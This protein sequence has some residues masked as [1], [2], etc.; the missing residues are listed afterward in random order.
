ML[1]TAEQIEAEISELKE[2]KPRVV[3]ES[4]FGDNNHDAIEA[5]IQTLENRWTEDD[6]EDETEN[7]ED[8]VRDA[9]RDAAQWMAD[10]NR[11]WREST[12]SCY[13]DLELRR[14]MEKKM[15]VVR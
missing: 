8:N 2:M 13:Y 14:F 3:E 6:V 15:E 4:A 11:E 7:D 9:A 1:K 12:N 10:W 5:Q